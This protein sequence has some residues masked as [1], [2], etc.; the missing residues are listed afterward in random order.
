MV[1]LEVTNAVLIGYGNWKTCPIWLIEFGTMARSL[2]T[3][4]KVGP[5]DSQVSYSSRQTKK[6]NKRESLLQVVIG[7]KETRR[8][9]SI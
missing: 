8:N 2:K 6:K 4:S 1:R 7:V 5:W 3:I 9:K